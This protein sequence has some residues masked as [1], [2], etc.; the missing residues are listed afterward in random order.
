MLQSSARLAVTLCQQGH[1]DM[2]VR[3]YTPDLENECRL[4]RVTY[5]CTETINLDLAICNA[6]RVSEQMP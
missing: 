6:Y 4:L 3:S 5:I 2:T 1:V